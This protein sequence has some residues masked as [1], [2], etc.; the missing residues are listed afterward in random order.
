MT[1]QGARVGQLLGNYRLVQPLGKG[2]F[3]EVFLGEHIH[4]GTQAAVKVLHAQ[5]ASGDVEGFRQEARMIAR[6]VHPHIVRVL[7]FGVD[8][9]LPFLVM[10]YAPRGTLR[11]RY[12]RGTRVA[13]M[14]VVNSIGQVA[15]A[16]QYAHDQHLIHRDIKPENML[17]G[18]NGEILLSDFGI[19]LVSQSSRSGHAQD[20]AGTIT[21]MAPEQI[22]AHARP[23]SD[24]YALGVVAYEW[25][26]GTPP[27]QG[28][29]AEIAIKHTLT[30]PQPLRVLLPDIPTAVEEVIMLALSKEPS[31][32]FPSVHA[33]ALALSSASQHRSPGHTASPIQR[34]SQPMPYPQVPPAFQEMTEPVISSQTVPR[35]QQS[36][37]SASYPQTAPPFQKPLTSHALSP[38]IHSP[39]PQPSASAQH[40]ATGYLHTP[41]PTALV[42][43]SQARALPRRMLLVGAIGLV[44]IGG[45]A[46]ASAA[47]S[48]HF[49]Q[50]GA[51][52]SAVGS[53]VSSQSV[54]RV[55]SPTFVRPETALLTYTGHHNTLTSIAWSPDGHALATGAIDGTVQVWDAV[56][57]HPLRV[58]HSQIPPAKPDDWAPSVSWSPDSKQLLTCFISALSAQIFDVASGTMRASFSPAPG[59]TF[60]AVSWSPHG[61]Y[62]ALGSSTSVIEVSVVPSQ[63]VIATWTEHGGLLQTLAW[64]PDSTRIATASSSLIT[65]WKATT[66]QKLLEYSNHHATVYS[67]SWSPDG[68]R[69][70]S[71][72]GDGTVQIWDAVSGATQM[73]YSKHQGGY[74]RA[75]AWSPEQNMI[76]SGGNDQTTHVWDARSGNVLRIY[77]T[78]AI[79]GVAWSPNGT[80]IATADIVKVGAQVWSV[81]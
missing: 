52:N 79:I 47:L 9:D 67:L 31:Q 16:L 8:H 75:V 5:L 6:L 80:K 72:A 56:S 28:T 68:A 61:K 30:S 22:Q 74:I 12:P 19:A 59:G 54:K 35:F 57:G 55:V 21:Y 4:L 76:A 39:D 2:G 43:S 45:V 60:M 64:S 34:T 10:D 71:A 58:Y 33:F 32:R 50:P 69:I 24:Q 23:A 51:S 29:Y 62:V 41:I 53:A 36:G 27:F 42:A 38:S 7:D 77:P 48:G 78:G 40:V 15:Q 63:Q 18:R 65:I 25:L 66:G 13:P 44:S 49:P 81:K 73:I 1:E 46:L 26:C 37:S 70:A 20:V 14:D 3:A 17:L 11:Q